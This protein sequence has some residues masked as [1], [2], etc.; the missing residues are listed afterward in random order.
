M[1]KSLKILYDT[2]MKKITVLLMM[3]LLV[4]LVGCGKVQNMTKGEPFTFEGMVYQTDYNKALANITTTGSAKQT[5]IVSRSVLAAA[6]IRILKTGESVISNKQGKFGFIEVPRG[7]FKIEINKEGYLPMIV[8]V[9]AGAININIETSEEFWPQRDKWTKNYTQLDDPTATAN[10]RVKLQQVRARDYLKMTK[11][12]TSEA[13]STM[14][15][16]FDKRKQSLKLVKSSKSYRSPDFRSV[17]ESNDN[18]EYKKN[19]KEHAVFIQYPI[20]KGAVATAN[21]LLNKEPVGRIEA[22][23]E[24]QIREMTLNKLKYR[25]VAVLK[26]SKE[27]F[28]GE[29]EETTYWLAPKIGII[30]VDEQPNDLILEL[31]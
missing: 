7:A 27:F 9:S 15:L 10:I 11:T 30:R 1:A 16:S 8:T 23:I 24:D 17:F 2:I 18:L 29:T 4:F 19:A 3:S 5:V 13:Y 20:S 25:N 14:W 28:N 21:I 22:K 12:L 31:Q 6:G 26:V